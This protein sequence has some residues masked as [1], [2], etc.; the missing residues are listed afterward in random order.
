[1]PGSPLSIPLANPKGASARVSLGDALQ[2]IR[3]QRP[4][5]GIAGPLLVRLAVT[6]ERT[7]GAGATASTSRQRPD[8]KEQAEGPDGGEADRA[9]HL[10]KPA[11]RSPGREL[12]EL[13]VCGSCSR[14]HPD[15]RYAPAKNDPTSIAIASAM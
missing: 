7:R 13:E 4:A 5:L 9:K 8:D 14:P 3:R 12:P 2:L 15:G 1:M 6:T 11:H 10:Y